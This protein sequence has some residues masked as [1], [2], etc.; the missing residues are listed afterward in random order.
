MH[1]MALTAEHPDSEGYKAAAAM[2]KLILV[3]VKLDPNQPMP[4]MQKAFQEWEARLGHKPLVITDP[5]Q[6]SPE[7]VRA[8]FERE[9]RFGEW[10]LEVTS[11]PNPE[12]AT[13][14]QIQARDEALDK[15]KKLWK[16][17]AFDLSALLKYLTRSKSNTSTVQN[18]DPTDTE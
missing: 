13:P 10:V 12:P 9:A 4:E 17:P 18:Q 11:N 14:E 7:Q 15:L 1:D 6:L 5:S 2:A 8:Y 3:N 16:R